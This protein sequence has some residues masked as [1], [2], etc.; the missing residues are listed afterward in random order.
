MA[1]PGRTDSALGDGLAT[2]GCAYI[3][4]DP[5]GGAAPAAAVCGA[6]CRPGSAY[7]AA[8]HALCHLRPGSRGEQQ[9]LDRIEALANA[10]GGR[11]ARPSGQPAQAWLHRVEV[12]AARLFFDRQCSCYVRR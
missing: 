6:P 11:Q 10:V 8:H 2:P 12:A 3:V 5:P 9:R 7:C 4:D 1:K